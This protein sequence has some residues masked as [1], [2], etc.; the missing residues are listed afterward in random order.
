MVLYM[1][2]LD[3][4]V[5]SIDYACTLF[6]EP[7]CDPKYCVRYLRETLYKLLALLENKGFRVSISKDTDLYAVYRDVWRKYEETF[8][9]N[10]VWHRYLLL[11]FLYKLG[12]EIDS[13]LLDELYNYLIEDRVQHFTPMYRLDLLLSY[14]K[15]L[16]Y[17]LVLTTGIASHDFIMRILEKHEC[18]KYFKIIFSTQLVGVK[19][20][21]EK[22]YKELVDLLNTEP[23]RILHIGDSVESDILPARRIGLK[24][25]YYGWRTLCR[26]ADPQPCILNLWDLLC[27]I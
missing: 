12:C 18:T 2:R 14:L 11:K 3:T 23:S 27:F 19:K 5:L 8:P 16:G 7:G 24:T 15:N 20:N 10:E 1:Y 26:P 6:W 9:D 21:N 25:I 4:D 17:E 22:F 13:K